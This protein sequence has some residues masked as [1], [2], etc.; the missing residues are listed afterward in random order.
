MKSQLS[1]FDAS[2]EELEAFEKLQG[3]Y[4]E[5]GVHT[6]I[7][8]PEILVKSSLTSLTRPCSKCWKAAYK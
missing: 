5:G 6:M 2:T 3:C 7:I 1:S 8:N 4:K